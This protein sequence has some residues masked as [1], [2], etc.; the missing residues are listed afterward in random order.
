MLVI[1]FFTWT[2]QNVVALPKMQERAYCS[3]GVVAQDRTFCRIRSIFISLFYRAMRNHALI[4]QLFI[5][6]VDSYDP[7][8]TSHLSRKRPWDSLTNPKAVSSSSR[9]LCKSSTISTSSSPLKNLGYGFSKSPLKCR[10]KTRFCS[11]HVN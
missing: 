9:S 7:S 4:S 6:G 2:S 8:R 3:G 5:L 11:R 10:Y 1:V